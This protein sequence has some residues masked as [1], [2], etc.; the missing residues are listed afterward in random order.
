MHYR[1]FTLL[2]AAVIGAATV[3]ADEKTQTEPKKPATSTKNGFEEPSE[4]EISDEERNRLRE[5]LLSQSGGGSGSPANLIALP[6]IQSKLN[7]TDAQ[8]KEI[9]QHIGDIRRKMQ[10]MFREVRD[11]PPEE[12]RERMAKIRVQGDKFQAEKFRLA[13]AVLTPA[14]KLRLHGISLQFRGA[15]ALLDPAVAAE[16]E[17]TD[18][19]QNEILDLAISFELKS[20]TLRSKRTEGVNIRQSLGKLRER[21]ERKT[22]DVLTD[23]QRKKYEQLKGKD[24]FKD[25]TPLDPEPTPPKPAASSPQPD[26]SG[27]TEQN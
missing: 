13:E 18:K 1:A 22:F 2:L 3:R 15:R 20:R 8:R 14:Q 17:L 23:E 6:V 11:L 21:Y 16:I 7:L 10:L 19:Q 9:E 5:Q 27:K 12:Q 24:L 25:P 4:A 26:D